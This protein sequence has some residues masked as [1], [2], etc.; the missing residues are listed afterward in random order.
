L[1]ERSKYG[2]Y[3]PVVLADDEAADTVEVHGLAEVSVEFGE[4]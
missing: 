3:E 1:D 2:V 4:E